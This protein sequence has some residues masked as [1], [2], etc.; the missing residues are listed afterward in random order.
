MAL[1]P[2]K[3]IC[4]SDLESVFLDK[5]TGLV[6]AGG[7]V[8]FYID[9]TNTP[10]QVYTTTGSPPTGFV[11]LGTTVTLDS[12]GQYSN[13]ANSVVLYYYPYN[14]AGALELYECRVYSSDNIL[15]FTREAWPPL[16]NNLSPSSNAVD[17]VRNYIPNGQFLAHNNHIVTDTTTEAGITI[18]EIAQGGWSF[19][20]TTSGTGVYTV[21][22][23]TEPEFPTGLN[24][25]P[26]FSVNIVCTGTVSGDTKRDL[27]I[28]WPDV[29][30]FSRTPAPSAFN[31]FFSAKLNSGTSSIFNVYLISNYG[32]GGSTTDET[33][34]GSVTLTNVYGATATDF[35]V[36]V[37]MPSNSGK[38]VGAGSFISIAIRPPAENFS[39]RFTNFALTLGSSGLNQFPIM[40]NDQQLS[41]SVAGWMPTPNP[42]GSDLYLPLVLTPEGMAFDHTVVG[43]IVGKVQV[44]ADTGE[45]LMDGNNYVYSNYSTDGIP[46]SR[47]GAYLIANSPGYTEGGGATIPAGNIPL[48]GTG[49]NFVSVWDAVVA[50]DFTVNFNTASAGNAF[51][52]GTSGFSNGGLAAGNR[53]VTF[54]IPAKPAAGTYFSFTPNASGLVFNVWFT[55]DGVG[56][57]PATPTGANIQVDIV[58]ADTI[59][60]TITKIQTAVNKYQF[61]IVDARGYFWRGNAGVD[62]DTAT[63]AAQI[64]YDGNHVAGVG[65]TGD[66]LGSSQ[67]SDFASH[68]HTGLTN[69][70]VIND[71]AAGTQAAGG[72]SIVISQVGVTISATGNASGDTRPDN[73]SL[74]WFIK[75]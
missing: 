7:R 73:L 57:A 40:T 25:S 2:K 48:F 51:S 4:T 69:N 17:G 32:T 3:F 62:P 35:N 64:V 65:V 54:T 72:G 16:A 61:S 5:L 15:Q 11:T 47:L 50:G 41:R 31:L 20:H 39:A 19:K 42:D 24:D 8:E 52:N 18:S 26:P 70:N 71:S 38:V 44:N 29:N 14:A 36:S 30:T 67:T 56:T 59:A 63:R 58:T 9:G 49:A 34:L 66:D 6:L 55:V 45:L 23:N 68:T 10:K 12:I 27:T 21:S 43:T 28:Q 60:T 13:G 46:Y 53:L 75:Y 1:D 37:P 22:F 74:N 33:L